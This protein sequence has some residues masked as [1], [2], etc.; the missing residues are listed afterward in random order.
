M[1]EVLG[2]A[3]TC[4]RQRERGAHGEGMAHGLLA[5]TGV[6]NIFSLHGDPEGG[7]SQPPGCCLLGDGLTVLVFGL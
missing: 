3:P 5:H 4:P 6:G 1:E 2:S 7:G